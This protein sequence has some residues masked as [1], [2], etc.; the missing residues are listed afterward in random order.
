MVMTSSWI[1]KYE[2]KE[3]KDILGQSGLVELDNFIGNFK[4][5][6]KK[7]VLIYGTPGCGKTSGVYALARKYGY[8]VVEVNASEF[9]NSEQIKLKVGNA[10]KQQ[11]LLTKG[12]II[13]VDEIDGIS[14]TKDRGGVGEI[15]SLIG[16]ASFPLVLTANDPW[17][18][19][20]STLRRKCTMIPYE[21]LDYA[22]VFKVLQRIC[23][24][25]G[26]AFEERA[27]KTLSRKVDGDLRAGINDLQTV[28]QVE[29]K[30]TMELV[31][32]SADR[33]RQES[34]QQAL[35]KV[36]KTS[37]LSIALGA[38]DHVNEDFDKWLLWVDENV[39]LE[40]TDPEDLV[41]AYDCIS[42]AAVFRG[43]IRRWQY[44]RFLVYV[45]ALLTA[46][47]AASKKEKTKGFVHYQRTQRILALWKAKMK[48]QKRKAIA[49]KIGTLTHTSSRRALQDT[50]P[51]LKTIFKNN[52]AVSDGLAGILDLSKEEVAWLRK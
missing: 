47:V 44:W 38:F 18:S 41:A 13:L 20:F 30:L 28:S 40:Y 6:K 8:E 23:V 31:E 15:A 5:Q 45:K 51:Y 11:S 43:R 37:D 36:F 12:K 48:Y 9:R 32:G 39:P 50:L 3:P 29:K 42:K 24:Q 1:K 17:H 46:G 22:T 2:P 21:T 19:K 4:K 14:G 26:I 49:E 52:Q 10:L 7:A 34:M 25:E 27:L 16:E 33:I 35:T